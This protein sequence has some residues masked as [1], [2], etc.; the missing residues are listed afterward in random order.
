MPGRAGRK[1]QLAVAQWVTPC[2]LL[3]GRSGEPGNP[4][5]SGTPLEQ[6]VI[7]SSS[8]ALKFQHPNTNGRDLSQSS[9]SI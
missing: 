2:S 9:I 7:T 3:Q 1:E 4:E 5:V 6:K 8:L